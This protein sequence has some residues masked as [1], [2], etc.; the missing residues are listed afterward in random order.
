MFKNFY[1]L[2]LMFGGYKTALQY[3]KFLTLSMFWP[4]SN[5]YIYL[6]LVGMDVIE[7]LAVFCKLL[8][9]T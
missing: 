9:K 6:T 5:L 4:L 3:A 1:S 8:P 2:N 7:W